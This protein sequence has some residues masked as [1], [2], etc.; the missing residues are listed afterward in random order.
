M[1]DICPLASTVTAFSYQAQKGSLT[2]LQTIATVP[3]EYSGVKE[4]AEIAVH[5]S[6]KFLYASN[7]GT[8]NSI[9]IFTVDA[10]KG[11]LKLVG[12]VSTKGQ[13]P[14]NF[15]I[16]PTGAFLLA[17][18]EDS[19]NVV[20]FRIDAATGGLTPTGQVEEV[21]APVCITFVPAE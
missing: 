9:T 17:A 2:A 19:G 6:G 12:E 15:V 21:A 13:T 20:V 4:A 5:P 8:A 14:R 7:R 16:D 10:A 18:N 3:K 1:P 11:T